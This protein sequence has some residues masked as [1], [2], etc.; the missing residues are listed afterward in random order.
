MFYPLTLPLIISVAL[1]AK[2]PL[3]KM[4]P[5]TTE[6]ED[7]DTSQDHF[8]QAISS[9]D[10]FLH[11]ISNVTSDDTAS[12]DPTEASDDNSEE[13]AEGNLFQEMEELTSLSEALENLAPKNVK[14]S[15][16]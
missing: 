3:T 15:L 2:I 4:D 8:H 12:T 11:T 6:G 13:D 10:I 14:V 7:G 5:A 1:A 16:E 9:L